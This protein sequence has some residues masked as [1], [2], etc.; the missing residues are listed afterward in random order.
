MGWTEQDILSVRPPI[1]GAEFKAQLAMSQSTSGFTTR[2]AQL[3][4]ENILQN[5]ICSV[6]Y[7]LSGFLLSNLSRN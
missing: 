2:S 4:E 1:S 7:P 3:V 5:A 6:E